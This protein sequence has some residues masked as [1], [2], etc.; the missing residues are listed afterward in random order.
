MTF[1][2]LR[3]LQSLLDL[4]GRKEET[5][6][7]IRV[8]TMVNIKQ[9]QYSNLETVILSKTRDSPIPTDPYEQTTFYARS[10]LSAGYCMTLPS[11]ANCTAGANKAEY[12]QGNVSHRDM[13]I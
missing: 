1:R 13:S 2:L 10:G 9:N 4:Q 6:E 12:L 5:E 3:G 11:F 8:T 7:T